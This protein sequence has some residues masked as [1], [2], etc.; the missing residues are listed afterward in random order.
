MITICLPQIK[1][2]FSH[3]QVQNRG[4]EG[5]GYSHLFLQHGAPGEDH[6][7][8][9]EDPTLQRGGQFPRQ[10]M[11]VRDRF[12]VFTGWTYLIPEHRSDMLRTKMRPHMLMSQTRHPGASVMPPCPVYLFPYEHHGL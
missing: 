9:L 3:Q 4:G 10:I 7:A 11:A 6:K 12:N 2:Q 8:L 1:A 5:A